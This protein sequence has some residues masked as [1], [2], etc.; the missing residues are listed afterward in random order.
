MALVL[1]LFGFQLAR[2]DAES[3]AWI[4]NPLLGSP[5]TAGQA[6]SHIHYIHLSITLKNLD[7]GGWQ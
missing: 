2:G 6:Y 3:Q 7:K 4:A 1:T 5:R